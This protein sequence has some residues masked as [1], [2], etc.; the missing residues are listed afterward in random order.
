MTAETSPSHYASVVQLPF[1]ELHA[2]LFADNANIRNRIVRFHVDRHSDDPDSDYWT[3]TLTCT[4]VIDDASTS[5][6]ICSQQA[7]GE[8]TD[9][10]NECQEMVAILRAHCA[11]LNLQL[12]PGLI[13]L[14]A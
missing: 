1:S 8:R 11:A 6:L 10:D 3:V 7:C 9:G 5:R 13:E 14:I 2:E 4:A 12:R